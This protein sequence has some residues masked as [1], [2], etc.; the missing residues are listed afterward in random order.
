M[1]FSVS[2]ALAVMLFCLCAC[3][4]ARQGEW[5]QVRSVGDARVSGSYWANKNF[6]GW[7]R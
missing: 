6:T 2:A 4:T 7:N 5:L 1:K 3:S